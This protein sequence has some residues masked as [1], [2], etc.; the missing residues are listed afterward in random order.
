MVIGPILLS[1]MVNDIKRSVNTSLLVKFTGD[2]TISIP[3][4][5]GV[6]NTA[7]EVDNILQ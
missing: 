6:D 7:I 5:N 1:V 3:V 4:R 2:I